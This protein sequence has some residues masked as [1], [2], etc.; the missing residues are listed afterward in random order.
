MF[1][2]F[3]HHSTISGFLK[4]K[5]NNE[6]EEIQNFPKRNCCFEV[7]YVF[8]V[9]FLK[10]I[11]KQFLNY[12]FC[13]FFLFLFQKIPFQRRNWIH[14]TCRTKISTNKHNELLLCIAYIFHNV[15]NN[16]VSRTI[17]N[18]QLYWRTARWV[19][20]AWLFHKQIFFAICCV[21]FSL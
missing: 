10:K 1:Y 15:F 7:F 5:E 2:I 12:E 11:R 3:A 13:V 9:F 4:W 6:K 17:H 16:Y 14:R 20:S 18:G 19:Y 21:H 8:F